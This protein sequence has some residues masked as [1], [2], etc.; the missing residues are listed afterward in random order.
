MFVKQALLDKEQRQSK[1]NNSSSN[2]RTWRCSPQSS[3]KVHKSG[4]CF[5][6]GKAGHYQRDCRKPP[7]PRQQFQHCGHPSKHHADKAETRTTY[8]S[9]S[10]EPEDAQIFIAHTDAFFASNKESKWIINSGASKHMTF[11]QDTSSLSKVQH[12]R[13]SG[14]G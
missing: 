6:C 10:T 9:S 8:K 2:T 11:Q 3:Y 1:G 13:A 5:N 4:V 7:K 12:T 14:T